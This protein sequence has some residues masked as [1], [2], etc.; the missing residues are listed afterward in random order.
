M[1]PF[2]FF[3]GEDEGV[4]LR[5][6]LDYYFV[7]RALHV[8]QCSLQDRTRSMALWAEVMGLSVASNVEIMHMRVWNALAG[9]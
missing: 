5:Q 9:L 6:L 1:P 8:E 4:G 2:L 3:M 7:L